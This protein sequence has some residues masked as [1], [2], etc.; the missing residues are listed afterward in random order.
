MALEPKQ[1]RRWVAAEAV[2]IDQPTCPAADET[3][4]IPAVDKST[5]VVSVLRSLNLYSVEVQR[6][7]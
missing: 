6:V 1:V 7:K 4:E 5:A 2:R 3:W